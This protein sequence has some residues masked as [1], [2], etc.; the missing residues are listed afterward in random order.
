MSFFTAFRRPAAAPES[1]AGEPLNAPRWP[2]GPVS[3]PRSIPV[4]LPPPRASE[5][6]ERL[7][8]VR[9][10]LTARFDDVDRC[11]EAVVLDE[12]ADLT[13][14]LGSPLAAAQYLYAPHLMETK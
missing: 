2:T 3:P 12:L 11:V 9:T 5:T 6:P 14:D 8:P 1:H 13:R 10:W 4:T 7:Y